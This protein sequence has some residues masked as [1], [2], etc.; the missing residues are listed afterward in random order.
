MQSDGT[1][2]EVADNN[3]LTQLELQR[4]M[5][6]EEKVNILSKLVCK[7]KNEWDTWQNLDAFTQEVKDIYNAGIDEEEDTDEKQRMT[8][9]R[10]ERISFM[11]EKIQNLCFWHQ[12]KDGEVDSLGGLNGKTPPE[13]KEPRSFPT[14]NSEVYHFHPIAFIEQMKRIVGLEDIDLRNS[15]KWISQF[16]SMFGTSKE[17]KVA[18]CKASK[19]I[20]R[21]SGINT[22]GELGVFSAIAKL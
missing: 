17:Q 10:D 3:V 1:I 15:V 11:K 2:E 18:C 21:N 22:G 16:N 20:L 12:V 8:N 7:H 4:A 13:D 14:N 6:K 19:K 5:R 9:V